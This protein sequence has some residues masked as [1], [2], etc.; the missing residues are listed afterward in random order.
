VDLWATTKE[1]IKG[2]LTQIGI[3]KT[4]FTDITS[5]KKEEMGSSVHHFKRRGRRPGVPLLQKK[6]VHRQI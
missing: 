5:A 1:G 3:E 4:K 2:K 6:G